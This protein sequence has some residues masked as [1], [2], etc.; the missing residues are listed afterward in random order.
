MTFEEW[1]AALASKVKGSWNLHTLLPPKLDFFIML[2]SIAGI[3]GNVGQANYAAGNTFEDALAHYRLARGEKGVSLDL[4]WIE[5]I[6]KIAETESLH[7]GIAS[8]GYLT[9]ISDSDL[10]ALLDHYCDP[11]L[12]LTSKTCQ[13]VVG[14]ATPAATRAAAGADRDIP[15]FMQRPTY[16]MMHQMGLLAATGHSASLDTTATAANFAALFA[17][18]SSLA[19]AGD[20]IA[21][22]LAR[23]LSKAL[24]M[25]PEDIDT[26]KPLHAYG[27]DSLL[28]VELRN[29]FAKEMVADIA[30]FNIMGAASIASLSG[31][32]AAK[33]QFRQAS[34]VE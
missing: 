27:V 2:S 18:A 26:S 30:I 7:K 21:Q 8:I 11:S 6:G 32:V 5:T 10:M 29:W 33:S 25:P 23:K 19:D 34:W 24:S 13:T 4:G 14:L 15:A 28:A 3:I 22:G 20:V 12:V 16:R 9:P 31:L 1:S 17:T